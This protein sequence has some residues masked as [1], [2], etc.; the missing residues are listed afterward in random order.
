MSGIVGTNAGRSSGKVGTVAV[1]ADAITGDEIADDVLDSEHYVAASIDNEHLADNAVGTDEIADNAVTLAKMAG[2]TDGNIISFD[3]SGNPV[4]IA[5]G[6]DGQV[7]TSAGTGAPPAFEAAAAGGK[8][9]QRVFI[10]TNALVTGTTAG[11]GLDDTIPQNGEGDQVLS[12]AITPTNSSNKLQI[13]F[14]CTCGINGGTIVS[15]VFQDST[16]NAI[17]CSANYISTANTIWSWGL[18]HTMA[19]GTTSST[20]FNVRIGSQTSHTISLNGVSGA[21]RYGGA[22]LTSLVIEEYEV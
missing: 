18:C 11:P 2:G 10:Q 21:R 12:L 4:A 17:A 9:V 3:A 22:A 6:S 15:S 7:L 16:A 13:S 1:G 5:T 20:T 8:L 19:A 14:G